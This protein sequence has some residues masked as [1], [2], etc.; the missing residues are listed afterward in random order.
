M[1][2]KTYISDQKSRTHLFN[3]LLLL[4][5]RKNTTSIQLF[6]D[7]GILEEILTNPCIC[8]AFSHI[9]NFMP[10]PSPFVDPLFSDHILLF[11][12]FNSAQMSLLSGN[13]P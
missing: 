3:C 1:N 10:C 13:I 12:F 11:F 7:E 5:Q 4:T 8:Y 9:H 2:E 6:N